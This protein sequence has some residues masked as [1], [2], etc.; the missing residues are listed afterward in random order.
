MNRAIVVIGPSGNGKSTLAS[1]LAEQLNWT[2]IEGDAHHPP[3]NVAKMASG[4]PLTDEDRVPFLE[5]IGRALATVEHG[6]VASC[7]ALRRAYRDRLR[8]FC[9]EVLFVWPQVPREELRRRM[10]GRKGHYMPASLLDSQIAAFETPQDDER[11]VAIDGCMPVPVQ[12]REIVSG[13]HE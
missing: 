2:F 3:R 12:V 8:A 1:A 4:E 5:N 7:S 6:A 10:E 11:F 9:P 13:L